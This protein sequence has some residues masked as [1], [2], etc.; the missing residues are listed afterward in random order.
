MSGPLF[1][2]DLTVVQLTR[3]EHFLSEGLG[4]IYRA[5]QVNSNYGQGVFGHHPSLLHLR[6]S[7]QHGVVA[8]STIVSSNTSFGHR[9]THIN[10]LGSL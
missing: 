6:S 10:F 8:K 4:G 1:L 3:D 5:V 7:G 2:G 9:T